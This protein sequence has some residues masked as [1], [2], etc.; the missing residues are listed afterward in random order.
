MKE[1]HPIYVF[2]GEIFNWDKT[3]TVDPSPEDVFRHLGR[4][5]DSEAQTESLRRQQ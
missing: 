2:G 1:N 3:Q 5:R 4:K